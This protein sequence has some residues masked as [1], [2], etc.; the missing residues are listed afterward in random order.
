MLRRLPLCKL[1]LFELFLD[2]LD[3]FD[4]FESVLAVRV[5]VCVR[6][7]VVSFGCVCVGCVRQELS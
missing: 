4:F 2:L 5:C 1:P 3:L 6:Q 7:R